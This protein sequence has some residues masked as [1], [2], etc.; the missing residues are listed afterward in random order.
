MGYFLEQNRIAVGYPV[1][2]SLEGLTYQEIRALL[3]NVNWETGIGNVNRLVREMRIGDLVVIP[4]DNARD[5]YFAEIVSDYLYVEEL[6]VNKAGTGFPHQ[7]SVKYFFDKQPVPRQELPEPLLESLR[8]PGAVADLSKH[9]E[10]VEEILES[11]LGSIKRAH[12]ATLEKLTEQATVVL[13]SALDHE[14]IEIQLRAAEI[15][16]RNSRS[17]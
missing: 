4:D 15:I 12:D 17:R 11:P 7:R 6:D 13:Q 1:G 10:L 14:D 16:L 8:Y 9:G 2:R 3:K 5:V